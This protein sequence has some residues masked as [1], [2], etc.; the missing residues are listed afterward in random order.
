MAYKVYRYRKRDEIFKLRELVISISKQIDGRQDITIKTQSSS[1]ARSMFGKERT[2][3]KDVEHKQ[4][5][6]KLKRTPKN[7]TPSS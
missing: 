7:H 5:Y 4:Q 1:T 6:K 3:E 2:G